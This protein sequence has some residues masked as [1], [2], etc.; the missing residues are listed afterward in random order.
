MSEH[1]FAT[2]HPVR[3]EVTVS[4]GDVEVVAVEGEESVLTL[5]GPQP[6]VD[7]AQVELIG[8]R[9]I[10]S[11]PRR[12][13]VGGLIALLASES[14]DVV[15][16][17]PRESAVAVTT[18]SGDVTLEGAFGGVEM[19]SA[20][21]DLEVAGEVDGD[22]VVKSASG[23]AQLGPVTGSLVAQTVSGDVTA[24]SVDGPVKVKSVS[25]DVHIDLLREGEVSIQS[26]SG[27]V[28]LGI[29]EGSCIDVD[30]GSTSGELS[31]EVPLSRSQ[32]A[33]DGP[34]VLIRSH[35]VS[36]DFRVFRAARPQ[37]ADVR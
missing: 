33:G 32:D 27:D 21:G 10:V 36:G 26:V 23:D 30:A 35:S 17:V 13:S 12:S 2:P 34:V 37:S 31:S 3:L 16:R 24:A 1:R 18:A 6:L 5:H 4:S 19:K 8:D 28:A 7:A 15:A 11:E 25:G 20:S 9:L 22:V 14:L 29:E